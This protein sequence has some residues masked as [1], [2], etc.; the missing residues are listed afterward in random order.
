MAPHRIIADLTHHYQIV[1]GYGQR[2]RLQDVM[3]YHEQQEVWN[4]TK[5]CMN[6]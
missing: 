3:L 2:G 6:R 5:E 4:L 1:V